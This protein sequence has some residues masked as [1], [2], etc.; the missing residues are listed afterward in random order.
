MAQ[1]RQATSGY[2]GTWALS[3]IIP[4]GVAALVYALSHSVAAAVVAV[5]VAFILF[6]LVLA[7]KR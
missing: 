1:R 5:I 2:A 7:K 3:Y 6:V 4:L